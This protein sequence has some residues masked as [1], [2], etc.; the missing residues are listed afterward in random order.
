M[1]ERGVNNGV[2]VAGGQ[3]VSCTHQLFIDYLL[4]ISSPNNRGSKISSARL[5]RNVI[6]DVLIVSDWNVMNSCVNWWVVEGQAV[7][8]GCTSS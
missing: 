6:L 2:G 5:I 3:N 4:F 1:L 7:L 8:K